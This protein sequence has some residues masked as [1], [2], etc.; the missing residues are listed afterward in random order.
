[1][2]EKPF[3]FNNVTAKDIMTKSP[4]YV[5]VDEMAINAFYL[6]E[7]HKITQLIVCKDNKYKGILH[8]HD[9]LHE[10]IV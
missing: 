6:M 7:K 1:M 4:K 5:S 3:D 8:I 9:I 2:L 10:G